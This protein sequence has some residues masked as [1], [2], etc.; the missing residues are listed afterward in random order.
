M[1]VSE[2][3]TLQQ[4][5][6]ELALLGSPSITLTMTSLQMRGCILQHR[7]HG[8]FVGM[9]STPAQAINDALSKLR[10]R[11]AQHFRDRA[12]AEATPRPA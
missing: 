4:L 3:T 9:G 2:S 10:E 1:A 5:E 7:D 11:I 6:F 8:F 12:D